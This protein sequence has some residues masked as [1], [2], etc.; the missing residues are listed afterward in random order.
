M[1]PVRRLIIN[2]DD[3][4]LTSGVNRAIEECHRQGVVTSCTLMAN[5]AAFAEA[6]AMAQRNPRMSVG[7]HIMLVDGEPL[8]PASS[9]PT[10]APQGA[11]RQSLGRFALAALGGKIQADEIAREAAAQIQKLQA[12]GIQAT[13]FDTHKHTHLLPAIFKPLL[14]VAREWGIRAVR[15][16]FVPVKPLAF[17]HLARRPKLWT[18][19]S[20]LRVL[21]RYARAFRDHVQKAGMVTTDGSF[22]VVVTGALD[23]QLFESIAGSIPEGT[24]E[25][26]CHPG[27]NDADLERAHTRLRKSRAAELEVLTSKQARQSLE[28]HGIELISYRELAG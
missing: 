16:P 12:A 24:W 9:I 4:G 2:A 25:L 23:A 11:L 5:S 8:L 20:E 14:E 21:R 7:C 6:A 15:N 3:C 26:V 18:R 17:A 22:G 10:L 19:Y 27:Y 28:K 13:H 1:P